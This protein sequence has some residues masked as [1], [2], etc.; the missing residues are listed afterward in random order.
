LRN[1]ISTDLKNCS[2]YDSSDRSAIFPEITLGYCKKNVW[3]LRNREI[4]LKNFIENEEGFDCP[5]L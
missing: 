5:R 3:L 2:K 4:K 1:F